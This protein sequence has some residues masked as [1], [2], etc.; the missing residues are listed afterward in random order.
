[1]TPLLPTLRILGALLV[2]AAVA[3]T[4][5]RSATAQTREILPRHLSVASSRSASPGLAQMNDPKYLI[6][7]MDQRVTVVEQKLA[8]TQRELAAAQQHTHSY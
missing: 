7:L 6:D 2:L 5:G 3:A 1:M 8:A 4:P